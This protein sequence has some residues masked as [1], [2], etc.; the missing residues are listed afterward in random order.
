MSYS[1]L[2][3]NDYQALLRANSDVLHNHRAMRHSSRTVE[4]FA[5]MSWGDSISDVPHHLRPRKRNSNE[6]AKT[7]YDQNNRR[8]YP[9][10]PCH[11]IP[12]SFYANFVHPFSDRNFTAR[13]GARIQSFPDSYV[14]KGKPTV[15]SQKLLEREGRVDERHLCQYSQIGNAVPPLM[16]KSIAKNLLQ[17]VSLSEQKAL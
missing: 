4:R 8:Q 6:I 2:P 9:Y 10:K 1:E 14:F 5:T 13:E 12:A 7:V 3:N 11:T 16:A 15:V 17:H